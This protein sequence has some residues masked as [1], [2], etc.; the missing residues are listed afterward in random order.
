MSSDAGNTPKTYEFTK[1]KRWADLLALEIAESINLILSATCTVLYCSPA[2]SDIT[3]WK[4]ADLLDRDFLELVSTSMVPSSVYSYILK[5]GLSADDKTS[6]RASFDESVQTKSELHSYVHV[7][8]VEAHAAY[9]A[10]DDMLF[11]IRGQSRSEPDG[12]FFFAAMNPFK[13]CRNEDLLSTYLELKTSNDRLQERRDELSSQLPQKPALSPPIVLPSTQIYVSSPIQPST[14]ASQSS[15]DTSDSH[16][17]SDARS[18]PELDKVSK[19]S[20]SADGS[21]LHDGASPADDDDEEGSK[22]KKLKKAPTGE[23]YV[24]VTCGRTDSPEWRKGP[25]G[26]KTLCN[27]CG[28]RWAKQARTGKVEDLDTEGGGFDA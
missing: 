19:P 26:P 14:G 25:L 27:A 17:P 24:C 12:V 9:P 11:E 10:P 4:D 8:C 13:S 28:L 23:H 3:G 18:P 21:T 1:R 16:H 15:I 7:K 20:F 5:E 22:R 2:V 6:F